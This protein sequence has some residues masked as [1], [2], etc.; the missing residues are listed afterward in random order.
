MF[1]DAVREPDGRRKSGFGVLDFLQICKRLP[2]ALDWLL[3]QLMTSAQVG[4]LSSLQ[5][6]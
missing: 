3:T 5:A 4:Q 1:E 6:S 2:V